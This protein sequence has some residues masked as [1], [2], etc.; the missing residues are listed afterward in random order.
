M[1][2]RKVV[3]KMSHCELVLLNKAEWLQHASKVIESNRDKNSEELLKDVLTSYFK[4]GTIP[5]V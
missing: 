4:F 1:F 3:L 5:Y 2:N